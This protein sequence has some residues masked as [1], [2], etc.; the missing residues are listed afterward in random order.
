[1]ARYSL[2]ALTEVATRALLR[3]GANPVMAETTAT[4]LVKAD[5]QGLAS[6]GVARVPQ[7]ATHLRNGR[8][9]GAAEPRVARE[10]QA[11]VLI[12]AACG[13]AFPACAMGVAEAIRRAR[14]HG[15]GFAGV[16]NSHHFGVAVDHL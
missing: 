12:D 16:T 1:M 13:L 7:Y 6:H 11:A 4:A 3:A 2:D 14:D 10:K 15:V 5:A 9:D 8:A